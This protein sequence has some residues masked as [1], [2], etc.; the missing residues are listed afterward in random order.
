MPSVGPLSARYGR[1][2][3]M[4]AVLR[5]ALQEVPSGMVQ[6]SEVVSVSH[7]C[8]EAADFSTGHVSDSE[9]PDGVETL[10]LDDPPVTA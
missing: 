4:T 1:P 5:S 3:S 7:L 10:L 2:W 8:H 9:A 6:A